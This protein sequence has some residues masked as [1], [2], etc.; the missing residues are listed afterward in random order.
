M[1]TSNTQ[2]NRATIDY[3]QNSWVPSQSR[4]K[5][6]QQ[7]QHKK[8]GTGVVLGTEGQGE[9]ERIQIRFHTHGVKW[10]LAAYAKLEPQPSHLF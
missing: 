10:L 7:V 5:L 9:D 2:H 8:F 3:A 1:R 4:W 6:G